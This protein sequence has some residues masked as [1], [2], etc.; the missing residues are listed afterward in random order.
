[1]KIDKTKIE[2]AVEVRTSGEGM[3]QIQLSPDPRWD[4][5]EGRAELVR[6]VQWLNYKH[7]VLN[8]RKTEDVN[9]GRPRVG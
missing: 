8:Q 5:E 6:E 1:M 9:S 2:Y 7:N 3:T 4:T